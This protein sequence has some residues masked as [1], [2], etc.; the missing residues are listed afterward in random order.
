M[1]Q[2]EGNNARETRISACMKKAR[3]TL[4]VRNHPTRTNPREF[5]TITIRLHPE[6]LSAMKAVAR[7]LGMTPEQFG[8]LAVDM[9]RANQN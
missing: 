3:L 6:F 4:T 7:D 2:D 5:Q 1:P 8:S 9:Y